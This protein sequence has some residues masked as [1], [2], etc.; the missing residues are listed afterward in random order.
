MKVTF[1]VPELKQAL[2]KLA[3]VVAK[4]SQEALYRKFR[5]FTD[6]DKIVTLQG[7]DI[8]TTMTLKLPTATADDV[9]NVLLDFET[10]NSITQH[11][12]APQV[13]ITIKG[14]NAAVLSSGKS[15]VSR[16]QTSPTSDF[17]DLP[18][19]AG[20]S[21]KPEIGG[22]VFGLPGIKAQI[23]L[24][25]FAVPAAEGRHVVAS[26][27]LKSDGKEL[28]V[29]GTDG[30]VLAIST[31][32]SDIGEFSFTVPKP[33]LELI[34]KLDGGPKVT[35]SDTE[36]AF[37][38][39]TELEL[40]TYNK[41]HAEFPNY[42]PIVTASNANDVTLVFK[43]KVELL[44]VL[45]RLR[46]QCVATSTDDKTKPVAFDFDGTSTVKLIVMKEEKLATGNTYMDMGYDAIEVEGSGKAIKIRFDILNITPFLERAAFPVTVRLKSS[47]SVTDMHAAGSTVEK[48]TYRYLS[49]PM[50]M[51][52]GSPS[53]T[54]IPLP[55]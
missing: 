50:H 25:A 19:V 32:P 27:L 21:E 54:P 5:L 38:L 51:V 6:A 9:V 15:Q 16:L 31:T 45:A 43:D 13:F 10:V 7:I 42:T 46:S 23:E 52:D 4:K 24:V 22:Y 26:A 17:T 18:L 44:A 1:A 14:E 41:T 8:D 33:A 3:S 55:E 35:I 28:H 20:I 30:V 29:V 48:P 11:I 39:E 53:S 36:G 12:T 37:F 49:M 34:K 2:A 40:V 47:S